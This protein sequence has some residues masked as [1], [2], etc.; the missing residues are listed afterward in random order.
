M[1]YSYGTVSPT[2][3]WVTIDSSGTI[4][5]DSQSVPEAGYQGS[6]RFTVSDGTNQVSL[7]VP[8][9]IAPSYAWAAANTQIVD[10]AETSTIT[11]AATVGAAFTSAQIFA[12]LDLVWVA[13]VGASFEDTA[14]TLATYEDSIDL[15]QNISLDPSG[16]ATYS[17]SV[18]LAQT[19]DDSFGDGQKLGSTA[20][21]QASALT[22]SGAAT[23]SESVALGQTVSNGFVGSE[24][25]G[26]P[27]ESALITGL[28]FDQSSLYSGT[29]AAD[30]A[31]MT[32]GTP[33]TYAA[34]NS[35]G[36]R[37]IEV[38][39]AESLVSGLLVGGGLGVGFGNMAAYLNNRQIQYWD[40]TAW[41]QIA[42]V[43]GVTDSGTNQFKVIYFPLTTTTKLRIFISG[44]SWVAT[45]D[46]Y[47][48]VIT[49]ATGEADLKTG[50]TFAQS[51]NFSGS[52]IATQA[53]MTDGVYTTVAATQ[54]GVNWIECSFA[55]TT[56]RGLAVANSSTGGWNITYLNGRTIQYWDGAAWVDLATIATTVNDVIVRIY[57]PPTTTT[58]LR[59]Y[60]ASS[61]LATS[62][63][64]PI[65]LT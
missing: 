16:L 51:S 44:T 6:A 30:Q 11:W 65:E 56:V 23:Y 18:G 26:A 13:T 21:S 39:F 37:W 35:V 15:S 19:I 53:T 59:I 52:T 5:V 64:Y 60:S 34:T 46:M 47:P 2:P 25:I 42:T 40:G 17:E 9:D 33:T 10:W 61:F 24:P 8:I 31:R 63:M 27:T 58:K 7:D 3:A 1:A 62:E 28:T 36:D 49:G 4:T 48:Y 12:P 22:F 14:G 45:A 32:D 50:L 54:S 43:S 20:L 55:E 38:S 29:T 57:F 41:V